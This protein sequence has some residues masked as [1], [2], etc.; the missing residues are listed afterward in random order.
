MNVRWNLMNFRHCLILANKYFLKIH[1]FTSGGKCLV[2]MRHSQQFR[3]R[4]APSFDIQDAPIKLKIW[5]ARGLWRGGPLSGP[6][7]VS[8]AH[9]QLA[10]HEP[11][12]TCLSL[13]G[14]EWKSALSK[15]PPSFPSQGRNYRG[16]LSLTEFWPWCRAPKPIWFCDVSGSQLI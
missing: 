5:G 13:I 4:L 10:I 6:G 12:K 2:F 8:G 7:G 3:N 11:Q 16:G 14:V 15:P 1:D 9:D